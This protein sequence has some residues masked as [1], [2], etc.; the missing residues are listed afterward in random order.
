[1]SAFAKGLRKT[2]KNYAISIIEVCLDRCRE[3][4]SNIIEVLRETCDTTYPAVKTKFKV[5]DFEC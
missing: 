4:K 3:K 1:L 2:L 5:F